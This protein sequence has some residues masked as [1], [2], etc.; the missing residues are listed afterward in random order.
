[1]FFIY[2]LDKMGARLDYFREKEA[3]VYL[4][5]LSGAVAVNADSVAQ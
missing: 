2:Y 3:V 4:Y 5:D 1:L